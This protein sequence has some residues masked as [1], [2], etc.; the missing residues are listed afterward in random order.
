MFHEDI[1][2]YQNIFSYIST[3]SLPFI[4]IDVDAT[5]VLISHSF[6][7][8]GSSISTLP[9]LLSTSSTSTPPILSPRQS[10]QDKRKPTWLNDFVSNVVDFFTSSTDNTSSVTTLDPTSSYT[11]NI[12]PFITSSTFFPLYMAFLTKVS[13]IQEP[14]SY[15]WASVH[16]E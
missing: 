7:H 8:F 4:P 14:V 13:H 6:T 11:P 3:I 5:D 15:K 12:F 9:I 16:A 10:T 2:P 1:F